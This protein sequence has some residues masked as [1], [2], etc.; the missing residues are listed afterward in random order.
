MTEQQNG[1]SLAATTALLPTPYDGR[2]QKF[3]IPT[4]ET[5]PG[6]RAMIDCSGGVTIKI[7]IRGAMVPFEFSER[8]GTIP[9][10]LN[11]AVRDLPHTHP[12]WR[13]TS[14]WVL[15]GKHVSDGVAVWCKPTKPVLRDLGGRN[16]KVIEDAEPG[17][18]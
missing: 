11:G 13:I 14:L 6:N 3:S 2:D 5:G 12:F 10:K 7:N 15:Q 4:P 9:L 18:D 17:H 1:S 8:W 16:Y